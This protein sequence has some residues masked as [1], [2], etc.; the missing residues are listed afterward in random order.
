MTNEEKRD[1]AAKFLSDSGLLCCDRVWEAWSVGTM[2]EEDFHNASYDDEVIDDLVAVFDLVAG[3][4][5][6]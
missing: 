6:V 2:T 3:N 1:I 4:R 5:K